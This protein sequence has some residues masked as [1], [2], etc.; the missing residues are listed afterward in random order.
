MP[1]EYGSEFERI[2]LLPH[3]QTNLN[4]QQIYFNMIFR[5][6][7]TERKKERNEKKALFL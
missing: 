2:D 5:K 4:S 3:Q 7:T 6:K 1:E